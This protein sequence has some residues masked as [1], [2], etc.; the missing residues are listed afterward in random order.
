MSLDKK[1]SIRKKILSE[2]KKIVCG[3]CGESTR[4]QVISGRSACSYCG[5]GVGTF[6]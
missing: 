1:G 4:I 2:G 3:Y 6:V 5:A